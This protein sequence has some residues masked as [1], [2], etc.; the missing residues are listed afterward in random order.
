[1]SITL[2]NPPTSDTLGRTKSVP[3]SLLY[4]G[5][6]LDSKGFSVNLIDSQIENPEKIIRDTIRESLFIG[7]SVM[8]SQVQHA[9]RLSDFVKNI[10]PEFPVVW[11]GI[12]PTLFP[13]QCLADDSV[14]YVI[15]GEGELTLLDLTKHMLGEKKLLDINGLVYE[16][17]GE[18][19]VNHDRPYLNL[20][21]LS[22]PNWDLLKMESYFKDYVCKQR[23]INYGRE[24]PIHSGR[25]CPYRCTF[26]INS[27]L[28]KR[29]WRP[30]S[31]DNI[32]NE[33]LLLKDKYSLNH[34]NFVDDNFFLDKKRIED[35]CKKVKQ[36]KIDFT[37][38]ADCRVNYFN[39]GYLNDKLLKLVKESGCVALRFGV[40]SGS[41]RILDTLKKDITIPQITKAVKTCNE[42][43]IQPRC[44]FMVGTPVEEE[45]DI[46]KTTSLIKKLRKIC[47]FL[48]VYG[49]QV[50]RPYP[51]SLL[52]LEAEKRGYEPPN[53]LREIAN[54]KLGATGYLASVPYLKNLD[55]MES[56]AFYT[57]IAINSLDLKDHIKRVIKNVAEKQEISFQKELLSCLLLM[58]S[59]LRVKTNF[60]N[61]PFEKR[62]FK[63]SL[64]RPFK[65][66]ITQKI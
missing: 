31:A 66:R 5:S 1:M 15:R 32:V 58:S 26:C 36:E 33:I 22:P 25:G 55:N 64:F 52:Y 44:S 20:N 63:S 62:A 37:Y 34:V 10:D 28:T 38:Q 49:P 19:K 43:K 41:Q 57:P 65:D 39:Q 21:S 18:I 54:S 56:I 2:V 7:F 27:V 17:K 48:F 29:K 16:H 35:F 13:K 45:P 60:L 42:L 59:K 24:L 9:L 53:S 11:G 6:F 61:F 23:S 47:P 14:D 51:G 50:Y 3:I 40:E 4:L 46:L 30:L 12:H 8:T